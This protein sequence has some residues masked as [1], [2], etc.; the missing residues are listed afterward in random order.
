MM[1]RM[2]KLTVNNSQRIR[3]LEGAVLTTIMID[4][5]SE[6]DKRLAEAGATYNHEVQGNLAHGLGSPHIHSWGELVDAIPEDEKNK[7]FDRSLMEVLKMHKE[8]RLEKQVALEV[9]ACKRKTNY[10][11]RATLR[12]AG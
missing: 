2:L 9:S 11:K 6:L 10:N 4:Q 8:D 12:Q 1:T 7:D 5:G 3:E